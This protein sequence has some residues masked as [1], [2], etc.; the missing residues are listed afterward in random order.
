MEESM[1]R[2]RKS[3]SRRITVWE[4]K[5]DLTQTQS[6]I[7]DKIEEHYAQRHP[8][9]SDSGEAEL[10]NSFIPP[11]CPFCDSDKFRKYGLTANGVQR[12][13]C[14]CGKTF[15]PTT[16]TIFDE[17]RISISE[18]IEYCMNLFRHVSISVDSW[19]NRNAFSTS[20][21]WLQKLFLT[22]Q[23]SQDSI[24][25]SGDVWLDETYYSVISRDALRHEDGKKLR[26]ISRNQFC[27]GVAT[28]KRHT[29]FLVEGYG[30]PSQK[31]TFET[32]HNH[33]A[34]GSTLIHDKE[35]A[36]AKLIKVLALQ[37]TVYA[38]EGLKGLPDLENPLE[39]VNRQH[40]LMK[41]FLNAHAGFLRENLQGYLDLF[42]YVTNPPYDLAEKVDS[43]INLVFHN[44]K[45]LR[46]RDFY[47]A[48]SSDLES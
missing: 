48:K 27:I 34:P 17:H 31:K 21:Y 33:I 3:E 24:V 9:L 23:G 41:H 25:L 30:K 7:K 4:G 29:L 32:F 6:F 5:N 43:L 37:S 19:N 35:Q 47:Q 13:R 11:K 46:Y 44:P 22:L 8:K 26:G 16:G 1:N 38:S 14:T 39:P 10:I 2:S 15:L 18:W 28:D 36:H 45:S 12:Y 40:A 20:R 42:S